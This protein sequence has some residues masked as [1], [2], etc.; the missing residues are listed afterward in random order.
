MHEAGQERG[1][2]P[3]SQPARISREVNS[4]LPGMIYFSVLRPFERLVEGRFTGGSADIRPPKGLPNSLEL[5]HLANKESGGQGV[6]GPTGWKTLQ[7][8]L[9][10]IVPPKELFFLSRSRVLSL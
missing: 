6:I 2:A 4:P 3:R 1:G 10:G 5:W 8:P 9:A 7:L